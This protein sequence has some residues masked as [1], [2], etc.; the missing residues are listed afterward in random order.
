VEKTVDYDSQ[1]SR[2]AEKSVASCL[3]TLCRGELQIPMDESVACSGGLAEVQTP[4]VAAQVQRF[5]VFPQIIV[6]GRLRLG[7]FFAQ[8]AVET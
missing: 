6:T 5:Q 1:L 4:V 7:A 2:G 3:F 8:T